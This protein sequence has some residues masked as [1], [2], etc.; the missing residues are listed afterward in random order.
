[1]ALAQTQH[2]FYQHL[3]PAKSLVKSGR[4]NNELV[5]P[6]FF[7]F[8]CL[9]LLVLVKA[10][11]FSKVVRIVQ[12]TFSK[13][14]FQQIEREEANPFKFYSLALN[15]LFVLNLSFLA[16]KINT[17]TQVVLIERTG[18]VQFLFFL[19]VI[20][21]VFSFKTLANRSLATFTN[22]RKI[23]SEYSISSN[24]V[25][26]SFGLFLFPLIILMEFSS[27]NPKVFIGLAVL[28]LSA[29]VL[30]KWYRGVLM[31]L[32]IERVGLLQIFSYF[33]GLEILPVF[34]LVKYIIETF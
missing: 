26:Q 25:N 16:Y 31:S 4:E 19:G 10:T 34:V 14:A 18:I 17:L 5:W 13:Q 11:S 12:S 27:L 7:L 15:L 1:V 33:C 28:V 8:L 6:S 24:L 3:L 29:S 30:I 32:V 21:L 2:I 22:E 23:I 20:L 9:I